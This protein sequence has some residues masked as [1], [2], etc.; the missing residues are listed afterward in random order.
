MRESQLDKYLPEILKLLQELSSSGELRGGEAVRI[1]GTLVN[2][3]SQLWLAKDGVKIVGMGTII[4]PPHPS[5]IDAYIHDVVRDSE[6]AGSGI[7]VMILNQLLIAAGAFANYFEQEI[8]VN[9]TS[10]PKRERANKLYREL[11]FT[12]S[13]TAYIDPKTKELVDGAT[14]YYKKKVAPW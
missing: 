3:A 8:T 11:G 2:P 9:L 6:Y 13:A 12:L 7:G 10:S 14:N 4:C 5:R 1:K